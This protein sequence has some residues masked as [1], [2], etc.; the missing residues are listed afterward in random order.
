MEPTQSRR[1]DIFRLLVLVGTTLSAVSF[2]FAPAIKPSFRIWAAP[3][4]IFI[5]IGVILYVFAIITRK[6]DIQGLA[7]LVFGG[8]LLVQIII[9]LIALSQ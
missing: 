7:S 3:S 6:R 1:S 4:L 5:V 2:F 9:T 8:A